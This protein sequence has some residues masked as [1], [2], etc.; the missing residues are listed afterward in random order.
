MGALCS[1]V[2]MLTHLYVELLQSALQCH[3]I[4]REV[5]SDGIV[6]QNQL[7]VHH[8]N[9]STDKRIGSMVSLAK[10]IG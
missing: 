3:G 4:A 10:C 1:H 9:L 5:G 7:L 8:F 6:Q 2:S